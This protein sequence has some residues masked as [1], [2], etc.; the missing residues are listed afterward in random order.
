MQRYLISYEFNDGEDQEIG[1]DML[2]EWYETGGVENRPENY[3]VLSWVFMI[4]NGTGH[5]VVRSDSLDTIW[6]LWYPWRK[7][8]DI[9]IQ[10]C[11]DLEETI[12]LI[13]K[14]RP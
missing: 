9:T 1:G 6:K 11:L 8:M 4:Q 12:S 5:C 3:E 13:K 2:V 14:T 10:P 7:L